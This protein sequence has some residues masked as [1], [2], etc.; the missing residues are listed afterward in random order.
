MSDEHWKLIDSGSRVTSTTPQQL[1]ESARDY[2]DWCDTHPINTK[3]TL[4]S[5]SQA[6]KKVEIE[7]VRPYTIKGFCL[8][9][10]ISERYIHDIKESYN[11]DS[12]YYMIMEKILYIIYSQN[13]EGAYVDIYNPIMVSKVL[14]LD[15]IENPND[16]AP[17]VEIVD[18]GEKRLYNSEDD[19]LK[20]LDYGK[21]E[22]V[23][24]KSENSEKEISINPHGHGGNSISSEVQENEI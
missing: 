5:G 12:D 9:A 16:K 11:P 18:N 19:V 8:H 4:Q 24:E 22:V 13:I 23:K 20:N 2:F 7:H 1:W 14:G 21:I 6:G 17:R 3:R 15:K 10:G